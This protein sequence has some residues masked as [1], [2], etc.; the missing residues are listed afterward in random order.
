VQRVQ[1]NAGSAWSSWWTNTQNSYPVRRLSK[2]HNDVQSIPRGLK[3]EMCTLAQYQHIWPFGPSGASQYCHLRK[4]SKRIP[5]VGS[6][7][8]ATGSAETDVARHPRHM[9]TDFQPK[10]CKTTL[11][12]A[13]AMGTPN[14]LTKGCCVALPPLSGVVIALRLV[15]AMAADGDCD[16]RLDGLT[17]SS[18]RRSTRDFLTG[19]CW[20]EP[21]VFWPALP[22]PRPPRE[23]MPE[24]C[25]S[26]G[27][28]R[29]TSVKERWHR[30]AVASSRL[31]MH[32]P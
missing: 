32:E 9:T 3:M 14:T 23:N 25:R 28:Q 12:D 17:S 29:A 10:A 6:L 24:G 22:P 7:P 5:T 4:V 31:G 21:C 19:V 30:V 11:S 2:R 27:L 1:N 16:M 26:G 20:S 15:L 8:A 13:T 18:W